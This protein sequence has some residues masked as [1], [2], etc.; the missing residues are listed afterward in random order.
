[1]NGGSAAVCLNESNCVTK[2]TIWAVRLAMTQISLG[3]SPV[4][5]E[6][7]DDQDD[8]SQLLGAK[9]KAFVLSDS[10]DHHIFMHENKG[11]ISGI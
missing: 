4:R 10:G 6:S 5:S 8:Q 2:P 11:L 7:S 1:M 9:H 3:I